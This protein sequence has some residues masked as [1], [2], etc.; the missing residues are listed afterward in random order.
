MH[1][2]GITWKPSSNGFQSGLTYRDEE[3]QLHFLE[4]KKGN[5]IAWTIEG[6]KY[7]IGRVIEDRRL[8]ACPLN[9]IV[10][11]G[12][13]CQE[14]SALDTFDPCI[15]CTGYQCLADSL[16]RSECRSS[17]YIIYLA[18]FSNG[19]LKVGVSSKHRARIRWVE[20]GADYACVLT[21]V[22]DGK[23]ARKIEYD[24][25]KHPAVLTAVSGQQKRNAL[26]SHLTEDDATRI[27]EDF[28]SL[29][30]DDEYNSHLSLENLTSYYSLE[31]LDA[32]PIPWLDRN[33][34]VVDQQLF[35]TIL[36]MKGALL[37]TQIGHSYRILSL[38]RLVGYTLKEGISKPIDSQSGLL[39][40][41]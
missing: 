12:K 5:Q 7:C 35:G 21:E 16:R 40:Y 9:S 11:K 10:L 25:G 22:I 19:T 31:D 15:R 1:V 8:I 26:L 33:Q 29:L 14:C 36:G 24:I 28:V 17:E 20:Q 23:K 41:I 6:P 4:L 39:D 2:V 18:V 27:I 32:E 3:K 34:S 38:K 13:K 37:V 30:P